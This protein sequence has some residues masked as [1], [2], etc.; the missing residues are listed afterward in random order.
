MKFKKLIRFLLALAMCFSIAGC[1]ATSSKKTTIE[2]ISYKQEA[3]TYF[4]QVAKEFNATHSNIELKISSPND[5]V[6]V[7]KTRFIREDYPDMIGIGGDATFSEFVDAGILADV[8]DYAGLKKVK[9]SYLTMLDQLEYVPTKGTYGVPYVANAAG[10][11]YSKK[12]FKKYGY[13]VPQ[14]WNDLMALCKQMKKDGVLP[15]YFGFKDTWTTLA[16][17]NALAVSLA[18]ATI[19]QSVNEGKTT[20]TKSYSELADK[21]KALL[22]YGEK[23]VAAYGYNDACT[24][25]A[26]G[27]SAMYTIGS[28]AIPQIL[29][30][31]PKMDIGSF[32]M[33]AN[34]DASKNN[35]N[36]GID[37]MFGVTKACKHKKEAYE[38]L[39]FLL[40]K[41]NL[42]KYINAQRAL[43][44]VTGQFT[45]PKQFSDM[46]PW[47]QS[48][49]MVDYQD[50]HYPST[51]GCDAI[52]QSY[53]LKGDK[54]AFLAKWDQDW[55][56][57]NRDI[58]R[59]VQDYNKTHKS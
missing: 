12:I 3:A 25:F 10:V 39:D 46:N 7:M 37:L 51:M 23:E 56:R 58:I 55:K 28:Y 34:N 26:K 30:S 1:G 17:W 44:C 53:L 31:N 57:Y 35:L 49:K 52:V 8:S 14:T 2:I 54:K 43:P 41:Q 15:F 50:H 36:S 9:K 45:L 27:Q 59:K 29:S 19:T 4:E 18:P 20:F 16:P 38:V 32:V 24:A 13:K 5:A 33:P 21:M 42:Q 47:I 48:G 11:L 6:T 40:K 22:Q